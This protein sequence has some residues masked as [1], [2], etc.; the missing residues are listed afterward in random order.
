MDI[1]NITKCVSRKDLLGLFYVLPHCRSDL[2]S[3]KVTVYSQRCDTKKGGKAE[4]EKRKKKK[5][6]KQNT[7][8][9]TII[10]KQTSK[11]ASNWVGI[12]KYGR[13]YVRTH[14]SK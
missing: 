8:K 10:K 14:V 9:Y 6:E 2:L 3:H 11:K 1:E 4:P 7:D 12:G 13:T 5:K